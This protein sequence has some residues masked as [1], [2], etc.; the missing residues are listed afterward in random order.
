[1]PRPGPRR[2][3]VGIRLSPDELEAVRRFAEQETNGNLSE[4][5][6]KL[7]AEAVKARSGRHSRPAATSK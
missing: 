5:I 3:Y 6:R 2:K 1:M 7:L 4:M